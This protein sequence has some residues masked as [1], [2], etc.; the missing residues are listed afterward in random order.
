[1]KTFQW[2]LI[3]WNRNT[4]KKCS[5]WSGSCSLTD[6]CPKQS[7][8]TF[9]LAYSTSATYLLNFLQ[10]TKLI[11]TLQPLCSLFPSVII[12]LAPSYPLVQSLCWPFSMESNY[13]ASLPNP[14]PSVLLFH[15]FSLSKIF[16]S[17]TPYPT[18]WNPNNSKI[19]IGFCYWILQ[20]LCYSFDGKICPD[21]I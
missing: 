14:K 10:E 3:Y 20:F 4:V 19:H 7:S 18:I 1:M 5:W 16:A 11:P 6:P 13:H 15:P 8:S 17:L 2:L 21:L 9:C 12:R